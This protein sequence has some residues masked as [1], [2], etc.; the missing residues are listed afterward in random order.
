LRERGVA[1]SMPLWAP[2]STTADVKSHAAVATP[3]QLAAAQARADDEGTS[4]LDEL[5]RLHPSKVREPRQL[6]ATYCTADSTLMSLVTRDIV[7]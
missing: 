6:L 3:E 1:Y 2:A 5:E 4:L 7:T